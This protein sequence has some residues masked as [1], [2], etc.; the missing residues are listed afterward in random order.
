MAAMYAHKT[1]RDVD[2]AMYAI[3][4]ALEDGEPVT[5]DQVQELREAKDRLQ[6][7]TEEF[8]AEIADDTES[9]GEGPGG[10]IPYGV[11]REALGET[12]HYDREQ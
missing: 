1:G 4:S 10:M 5:G 3:V 9:W 7:L 8:L 12:D 6:W 11:M 2:E